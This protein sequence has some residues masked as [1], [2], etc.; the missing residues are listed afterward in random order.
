MVF[1]TPGQQKW[2]EA[3][4]MKQRQ[5]AALYVDNREPV[6]FIRKWIYRLVQWKWFEM[7]IMGCIGFNVF[8]MILTHEGQPSGLTSAQ[9]SLGGFFTWIFVIECALKM[10]GLGAKRYFKDPWNRFD[11]IVVLGSLPEIF[12][13]DMGCLLYTSDAADE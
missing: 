9:D 6:F 8:M 11:F 2:A 5:N 7:F 1:T 3:L 13:Q 10:F 4:K 12:G